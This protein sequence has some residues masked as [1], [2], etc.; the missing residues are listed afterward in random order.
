MT[1]RET[2]ILDNYTDHYIKL[3]VFQLCESLCLQEVLF[4]IPNP[5]SHESQVCKRNFVLVHTDVPPNC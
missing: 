5:F 3:P 4:L 2:W 1:R